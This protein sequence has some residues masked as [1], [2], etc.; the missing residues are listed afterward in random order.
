MTNEFIS[1]NALYDFLEFVIGNAAEEDALFGTSSFRSL[2]GSVDEAVKVVRCDCFSGRFA[3][4]GESHCEETDVDFVVE[5]YVTPNEETL[6]AQDAA[7]DLSLVMAKQFY[8]K[9]TDRDGVTLRGKV[10][11]VNSDEFD[12]D[13]ASLGAVLRGA[14]YL[15]GKIN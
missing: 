9:L 13:M 7:K 12:T 1:R 15:Y 6:E 14:T 4:S 2:K 11:I 3:K 8:D 5:F 10:N